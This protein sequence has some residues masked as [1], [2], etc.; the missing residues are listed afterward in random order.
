MLHIQPTIPCVCCLFGIYCL[1]VHLFVLFCADVARLARA[2]V[3]CSFVG[4][5]LMFVGAELK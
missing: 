1:V 4:L 3:C 5:F 2:S